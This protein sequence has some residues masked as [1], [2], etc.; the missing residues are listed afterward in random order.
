VLREG[1][2]LISGIER[3]KL[4]SEEVGVRKRNV[5]EVVCVASF[6]GRIVRHGTYLNRGLQVRGHLNL[7]LRWCL[8]KVSICCV[9]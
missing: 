4:G 9:C 3:G 1:A 2:R 6:L 5:G 7:G 8:G